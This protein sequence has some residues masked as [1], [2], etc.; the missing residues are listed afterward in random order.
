MSKYSHIMEVLGNRFQQMN[1][2]GE[3]G[4]NSD[5]SK[6][7]SVDFSISTLSGLENRYV[8]V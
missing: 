2:G 8:Y 6:F 7:I 5:H 1:L 3:R 4:L